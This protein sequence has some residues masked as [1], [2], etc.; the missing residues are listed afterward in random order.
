M[1]TRTET[2]TVAHPTS[3]ESNLMISSARRIRLVLLAALTAL[4]VLGAT[5]AS[6]SAAEPHI[7]VTTLIPDHVTPG[8]AMLM[9]VAIHNDGSAPMS[10]NLTIDYSFPSGVG[11]TDPI[12]EFGPA[13]TCIQAAQEDECTLDA[14]GVPPGQ[15]ISYKTFSFVEPT[16]SGVLGGQIDVSGGGAPNSEAVPFSLDT[17]PIGPFDLKAL[18]VEMADGAVNPAGQAGGHPA[19]VAT[20][21]ETYSSAISLYDFPSPNTTLPSPPENFR[22]VVT[23]IPAGLVGNPT[24]TAA[25]CTAAEIAT[26][27]LV[28]GVTGQIPICPRDSQVGVALVNGK[29]VAPVYNMV[30]PVGVPALFG[31]YYQGLIVNL[32]ARLRPTDNGVDIVSMYSPSSIPISKVQIALWGTPADSSHDGL[33]GECTIGLSGA[34]GKLCPTLASKTPFL[35]QPTSC[36]GPLPWSIEMDTYQHPGVFHGKSTITP[37]LTGCDKVPFEPKVSLA[38]TSDGAHS[39]SGLDVDLSVPQGSGSNGISQA[40]VRSASVALPQGVSLNP[41]AAEGLEACSDAQLRLGIEGPAECPDAAKLGTVEVDT[42]LL[43]ETLDGSVYLRTQNSQDPESGQMYRLAIVLHSAERGVDVKLPGS[44]VV[45]KDTGQLTTTFDNLPQLPFETMQ[46]H[47]KAGPRAPLTT[48]Q[49]CGTYHA[50]ATLTGWNGKTV[51]IE[52]SFSVN[53]GCTA[54]GFDPGFEAGVANPTAGGFSPFT[55]RVTRD[56]G[57]PN[58]SRIEATLPEGELAKLAGV[59]VCSDAQA[60][61]GACPASSRIGKV[62]SA[63][64]EG[65]SPIY[66]P[67]PGKAPSMVYLAGPY[68]GAPYSVL[69]AVPAQSGPFDLGTVVVRSALRIDPETAQASVAS[70][71]LPQIFGGILVSYRDVRVE[72]DRP[73]FTVNPTSCEP[74]KVTGTIGSIAGGSAAVSDRF[75]VSDCAALGFKPKLSISLSG[76]TRRAGNPALT[77]VLQVPRKGPNANIARTSVALPSSEFLAQDHLDHVCTRVQY[78]ADGGGGAGCPKGSVYGR[79]RAFTPLLDQPL[80]G[81][82]YLRSNGGDRELPDLVASLGGQIH[83]DLVGYIDSNKKTGGIRTTF[84]KVPDAPVSKFVLKMPGGKKSLL[85]NS[86]NICHGKHRAIVKMDGQNGKVHDFAPLVR[87]KCGKGAGKS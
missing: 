1:S 27:N 30:Q 57:Q 46:L 47:L 85:E 77:A 64:G 73:E 75:Q 23:H 20:G 11:V 37:A 65:S 49:A 67:Q 34:T 43:D 26:Q 33:R 14:T 50:G 61:T 22:N 79:A 15:V 59:P 4:T 7:R 6:A 63:V 68:K 76:K 78:A 66:L 10:G 28:P 82:L 45:N 35:R 52:P 21:F 38:P 18:D 62:T 53:Q 39:T 60:A 72:V 54:P 17:A 25:K 58:L 5:T 55:L 81:P 36:T 32:R 86:T 74:M 69:A 83:V 8:D 56:S 40:D 70:D 12:T 44:L 84:A 2:A 80:E 9:F 29:D 24:A 16:A 3:K 87:A 71:P 41:A 42:P 48:P 31:I 19:D 13:P 51:S